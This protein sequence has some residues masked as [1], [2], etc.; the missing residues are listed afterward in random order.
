VPFPRFGTAL[1]Q[2]M[3]AAGITGRAVAS[4][5][6]VREPAVSAWKGG[7][8]R[9]E[10]GRLIELAELVGVP[11]ET[12]LR[13]TKLS[14]RSVRE[15]S[16]QYDAGRLE[17][18]AEAVR[19]ALSGALQTQNKLIDGLRLL[20]RERL[21]PA[22]QRALDATPSAAEPADRRASGDQ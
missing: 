16:A 4:R 13:D 7:Y 20:G 10:I 2:A 17:G 12:F 22:Q 19:D 9:P 8:S 15:S 3:K 21:S 5:F 18:Y 1:A 14:A 11:H 6:G